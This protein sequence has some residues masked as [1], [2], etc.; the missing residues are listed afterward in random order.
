MKIVRYD[1]EPITRVEILRE[2]DNLRKIG[3]EIKEPEDAE[4]QYIIDVVEEDEQGFYDREQALDYVIELI[5][6]KLG[7]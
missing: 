3:H 2:I 6:E 4:L 1:E 5:F 7:V